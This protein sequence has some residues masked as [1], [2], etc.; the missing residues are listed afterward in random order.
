MR[1]CG[2]NNLD[3]DERLRDLK[4]DYDF[5]EGNTGGEALAQ[6]MK[7][8]KELK[9]D[10]KKMLEQLNDLSANLE[11]I[12]AENRILR[13]MNNIP[14][15]WG[16]EPQKRIIKLQD[17]ETVFEY[18]RLVKILQEDNY[19]LEKER[20]K[21]KHQLKQMA[22]FG[23]LSNVQEFKDLTPEQRVRLADFIIKLKR[24]ETDEDKSWYDLH[25][26]NK[27]LKKELE[28]LQTKG[29]NVIRQQLEAFFREN[30]D[31][32]F[33]GMTSA[34]TGNM[35]E[36][37]RRFMEKMRKDQ[38]KMQDMMTKMF[39][40]SRTT[41]I[42]PTHGPGAQDEFAISAIEAGRFGPPRQ[43]GPST[44]F[45]TKFGT[46]LNIPLGGV[47][48]PKDI[49]AL[50]LQLVEL[51]ALNDRK[52]TQIKM[53]EGE[54]ERAYTKVRK[55]LLMQDQ[56]YLNYAEEYQGYKES[57][58][59]YEED[60]VKLKD[61]LREQQI[62]NE[63]LRNSIRDLRLDPN[64]MSNQIVNL[65]K[66]LA[67]IEVENFKMAKKYAIIAEQ[68]K[69]LR[70]AYHKVEEGFTE[71]ERYASERITKLKEWQIQAIN[72][73]KFLYSKFKDAVP[74]G[75][76][77]N[78]SRE[79][80][81]YKQKFAD[82]MEK[83]NR[84]CTTN[85]RLQTEN[86]HLLIYEEKLKLYEEI[87]IDAENELEIIK[88]RLEIV[89]P[90]FRWENAIF[91]RIIAVLKFKRVSPQRA[92][93]LFDKDGNGTL[94]DKE[95]MNALDKLGI[96]DLNPKE[97]E[98]LKRS[99]D[100][101]NSGTI[102]YREF[103]RKCGRHGVM[104][105]TREDEIVYVLDAALKKHRLDLATMFEMMDKKGKGVI[106]K[107]DFK[108]T[109]VNSRV[110]IDKK[111][112]DAFV[113][114]FWKKRE[115][116]I[117]YRDF[118]RIYNRFKVRFDES[119]N[120]DDR[121]L[122]EFEITD[123]MVERNKWIYD[124]LNSIFKKNDISLKKAFERIDYS[125]DK[126]ITR[127]ELRQLFENMNITCTD[128]EIEMMFKRMDFDDSGEITFNE[129]ESDFNK[130]VNTDLETLL[131][132][133]RERKQ[134]S[135]KVFSGDGYL[136]A[137]E[138][139][140]ASR[141]VKDATKLSILESKVNQLERKVEMY[142]TRLVK[143][144][145]SQITWERDYD[146]LEKKYFETNERY[147]ELLEKEQAY[148]TQKI[149][150]LKKEEAE[151]IV[152]KSERQKEQI[153]DLQAA[154]SSYKSLF[155]VASTQA[156]TLKLANKRSRDEEENLLFALRELQANSIDKMKLGRIYYILMLSRWQ[157]AAIGMK[158][159]YALNDVRTLRVEYSVVESRLKKE[160]EGRHLS[161]SKL[162]DKALEVEHLKQELES[163][164]ASGISMT[165]AEEI[166]RSLQD[167]A[168]EKAEVEEQFIKIYSE[169][170]RMQFKIND[171]EAKV[172]HYESLQ[173]VLRNAT[174]S[175][176]SEKLI[177]MADKL[178]QIRRNELRCKRE[179]EE[180]N[181]Q[182]TYTEKRI[183]HQKKTIVD[184]EDKLADL[185][186]NLHRK[187]EE[188]RRADNERQKKF[189]D[190]Q[191]V[192]FE[193]ESRYK[194][195][196]DDKE[197][198]DKYKKEDLTT[199][200]MGEFMIK[201][202]D[203]R[204]MQAK[205]RNQEDEISSLRQQIISKEK[206]LD[207]LREWQLEDNLLSEDEKMKDIIDSNKVK[208]DQMHEKEALEIT[209][210]AHKSIRLLKELAENKENECK[211]KDEIIQ[212]LKQRMIEQKQV[213]T[214][215]IVK[216]NEQL[217]EALK[218][219]N[220]EE[221][222]FQKVEYKFETRHYE[223]VSRRQLE[224]LCYEKDKVIQNLEEEIQ[225][226]R[227]TQDHL[228]Q[229]K[230]DSARSRLMKETD[231]F[232]TEQNKKIAALRKHIDTL[233]K[234]LESKQRVEERLN[235]T[236]REITDK[237]IRLEQMKGLTDEDIKMTKLTAKSAKPEK[238]EDQGR[239]AELEKMLQKKE[240]RLLT[241]TQ[242][243]KNQEK[244]IRDMKA[245]L[246][247]DKEEINKLREEVKTGLQMRQK[248][249]DQHE[250]EKR[251]KRRKERAEKKAEEVKAAGGTTNLEL[252]TLVKQVERENQ[253]LKTQ[254]KP[255]VAYNNESKAFEFIGEPLP[256]RTDGSP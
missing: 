115:E 61:E 225:K 213:D 57:L 249:I 211:R 10:K 78:V 178:F 72:E 230:D 25:E 88:K 85:A 217:N 235:D 224:A 4:K 9:D 185:E 100:P 94:D 120:E 168:D 54:L 112:L 23:T 106:T 81:I 109:L 234:K 173:Q 158:Y 206:Q 116:G 110:N 79:L 37:Q 176:L 164:G 172:E 86:R 160:E 141:E 151:K 33:M 232:S 252:R 41:P 64:S 239:I 18:K 204:V 87:R 83:N 124:R 253:I 71:R 256:L 200:P 26:E 134:K 66:K 163:K 36:E 93:E 43:T 187:E 27:N 148:N 102:D 56:L 216:L 123:E 90:S 17:R 96:T 117:N 189:F 192:N 241:T 212:E 247:E 15:N 139:F 82:M 238:E 132:L 248:L 76:Y 95:F 55:Y 44:G 245:K 133:N 147:Q 103:C 108:D 50:Q 202:A 3:Y 114:L 166:S 182:A 155:E 70:D 136:P 177:E 39:G 21:L 16:C 140:L 226:L 2:I 32:L 53:L 107:E 99:I 251:E 222:K 227:V 77:Q 5:L 209:Q 28:I 145:E 242:R 6:K 80:F 38:E 47:A 73:L 255:I 244:E 119:T 19:N 183:N 153:V 171:L 11:D 203:V 65:H 220:N 194:G 127:V 98:L 179:A 152:L 184:L 45:S 197:V 201:K 233:T 188:W 58:K 157:E 104:I 205:I 196:V 126:K 161:E 208:L 128:K 69:Q 181:E 250:A 91:N 30:K 175:E 228:L 7:S 1:R 131:A 62:Q 40:A 75:D 48:N 125:G 198:R 195:Y 20:A 236:V 51:F 190:A 146:T 84:L 240:S 22:I 35:T 129:F 113:N 246:L 52:D 154:M 210:A 118:V 193:T 223:A 12:L 138:D 162:R 121:P 68:E 60:K 214:K 130:I 97:K 122:G 229:N 199:P 180:L 92:F 67:L 167:M 237:L 63:R 34:D 215:E 59:K 218:A 243:A 31:T 74:L 42:F 254:A 156:K 137:T 101:D 159:D 150:T 207:R 219:K 149:G 231:V 186:S 29:Y 13:K 135:T 8:I 170:S 111:D 105:R 174:D 169:R 165:R 191:F 142:R 221:F 144:E 14:D 143:S 46:N 89:D 49:P 24:G